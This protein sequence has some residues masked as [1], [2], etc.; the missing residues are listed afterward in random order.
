ML[1]I[2]DMELLIISIAA[3]AIAISFIKKVF[4][5]PLFLSGLIIVILMYNILY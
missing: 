2:S 1:Y 5:F 4:K 3:N